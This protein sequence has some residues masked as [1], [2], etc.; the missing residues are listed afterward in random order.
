MLSAVGVGSR[1]VDRKLEE[2]LLIVLTVALVL[3]LVVIAALLLVMKDMPGT[4]AGGVDYW[5]RRVPEMNEQEY[6]GKWTLPEPPV[7][8]GGEPL[9]STREVL[10]MLMAPDAVWH[11]PAGS[12]RLGLI[13][14]SE[15]VWV[16]VDE[17]DGWSVSVL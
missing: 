1:L 4:D 5:N 3:A 14:T 6:V 9:M 2:M 17:P 8:E 12:A 16:P 13:H 15:G 11:I 7:A 10:D